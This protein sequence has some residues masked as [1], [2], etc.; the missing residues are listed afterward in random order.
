MT[1]TAGYDLIDMVRTLR[2]RLG[3]ILVFTGLAMAGALAGWLMREKSYKARSEFFISNPLYADRN[4]L[5]RTDQA[6]FIS[7]FGTEDDIDKV[8]AIAKSEKLEGRVIET[9]QLAKLYNLDTAKA[10]DANKLGALWM[11]RFDAKRTEY[12]NMSITYTDPDPKVAAYVTNEAVKEIEN[13]YSGYYTTLRQ[14]V[15]NSLSDKVR[16]TDSMIQ[17]I[18]AQL[19]ALPGTGIENNIESSKFKATYD[20][21]IK[22]RAKYVSLQGE[23]STG[24][25]DGELPLI[26]VLTQAQPPTTPDGLGL[27]LTLFAA[28]MVG[29]FFSV[30]MVLLRGYYSVLEAQKK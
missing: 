29:L 5:F 3:F 22:D 2:R 20:Q 19:S 4:N 15:Y 18:A 13:M 12:Q 14:H 6:A 26:N 28:L 27:G 10:S 17:G 21:L 30:L 23:F 24:T 25:R 16:E 7:Y 1:D 8:M 11:K 9:T